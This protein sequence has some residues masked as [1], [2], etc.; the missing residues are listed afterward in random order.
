MGHS[1]A[2]KTALVEWMLY[3]ENVI[4][5]KPASGHHDFLDSDPI[6]SARHS[7]IFSHFCRV[8]HANDKYLLH[9]A[10]T[11]WG[12]FPSDAIAALDGADSAVV[13]V[14]AADGV[15][16]GVQHAYQHCKDAGIRMMI[17]LS[18]LDR[19]FVQLQS[20]LDDLNKVFEEDGSSSNPMKPVSIQVPIWGGKDGDQFLGVEQ[21]FVLD[22]QTGEVTKNP[23]EDALLDDA[24]MEL[25]EAVAMTDDD[26][27]VEYLEESKLSPEQVLSGLQSGIR[28]GLLVPIV[29]T[30]A[31]H[32]LG[33]KELMD[34]MVSMLPDPITM[35]EEA[36]K[37]ACES[38]QG[39][40]GMVPGVEAGFAARVLHTVVDSFGSLSVLR[41][42]SNSRQDDDKFHSL[43]HETV[44]LRTGESVRM[45]SVGT[46]FALIGKERMGLSDNASLVPGDV[47]AVPK[48]PE[49]VCTNDILTIKSAVSEEQAEILV[50]TATKVLSPLSRPI[51]EFPLM[52]AATVSI[53][54]NNGGGATKGKKKG[55][56]GGAADDKLQNALHSMA[57][58]DL[59]MKV[60]HDKGSGKLLIRCMSGEHI[61]IVATRLK[62]RYGIDVELGQPPVQY[63][64]TLI[65][66]VTNI[67]GKHKKQSGGSG[68]FGVC[69]INMEPLPE[70]TGIEFESRIKGGVI[71]GPFITSVEKGVHEEL[72]HY[73]GPLGGFPV[74]DVKITLIDGKMHSVD[75]KDIAFQTAGRLAGKY[76]ELTI[77]EGA[78]VLLNPQIIS[79]CIVC[80]F[81]GSRLDTHTRT[82]TVKKALAQGKTKL[83]QPMES[84]TF[85]VVDSLQGDVTGLVA[86]HD[87]YVTTSGPCAE[88][89]GQTEVEAVLPTAVIAEISTALRAMTSGEGSFTAEFSH[90][91]PVPDHLL[92]SIIGDDKE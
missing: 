19:P 26:L 78:I 54:E 50:E 81:V 85:R 68:Q 7:S 92:S 33:V 40:C 52:A 23:R 66:P 13:V 28:R 62:E 2:G 65:K 89:P 4:T 70:G 64:E 27:L 73:G 42:I 71:S 24:W 43:P 30:S 11:P 44:N 59:S 36:L 35:R 69:V 55:S 21:L 18:K 37:A 53:P 5:Q 84:V 67:E 1:H 41:V 77:E 29:Y 10:D 61:Q 16:A 49:S 38:D 34:S 80:L 22:P 32:D 58:E 63:R 45:P 6:E 25:E 76:N 39:K 72:Q 87:G 8:P 14:S 57:R 90:Y 88:W 86:R 31:E 75:S 83:L 17:A 74:T 12:D 3:D 60:E 9:V 91:Q 51:E 79:N 15:Q 56:S 46:S 82:H 20:V 48:L 47:I